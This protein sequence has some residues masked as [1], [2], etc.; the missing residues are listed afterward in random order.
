M[1]MIKSLDSEFG[2][3][4]GVNLKLTCHDAEGRH[5]KWQQGVLD[6]GRDDAGGVAASYDHVSKLQ[7]TEGARC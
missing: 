5:D 3:R 2:C 6:C 4:T 1:M 7:G